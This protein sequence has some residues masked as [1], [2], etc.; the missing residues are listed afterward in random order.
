LNRNS[1]S[2]RVARCAQRTSRWSGQ[3]STP[4]QLE[5]LGR[6]AS[7]PALRRGSV[8]QRRTAWT[9][10]A[11]GSTLVNCMPDSMKRA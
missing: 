5:A 7:R 9:R 11:G 3:D 10:R 1:L 2:D 8:Q 4:S 6:N